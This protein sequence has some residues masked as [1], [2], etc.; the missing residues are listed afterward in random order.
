MVL[1]LH[2]KK[3]LSDGRASWYVRVRKGRTVDAFIS[4]VLIQLQQLD[5]LG[6]PN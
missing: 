4:T 5:K 6:F 3:R 1:R 2:E